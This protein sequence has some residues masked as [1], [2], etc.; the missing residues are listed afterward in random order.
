M[1]IAHNLLGMN[2]NRMY[3]ITNKRKASLTEKL[4]SGYKINRSAD[5]AAGL[6]I[7]EKMR[8][9]IRGLSQ[10]VENTQDGVSLCQVADGALAEVNDMLHRITEL[11]VK[12]ANGTNCEE[13]RQ[14]I[15][16]EVN[17]LL[18]EIDRI[19]DT[20]TF[21]ERPVFKGHDEVLTNADGSSMIEGDIPFQ[22]FALADVNLGRVPFSASSG[23]NNLQLQAI[24][25]NPASG[26]YGKT[27][28]LIYG[29]GS[30]S[31]SSFR[32]TDAAG[33]KTIVAL[34]SLQPA[35]YHYDSTNNIWSRDFNYVADGQNL[36]ITQKVQIEETNNDEKNY[37]ISYDF[38]NQQS[39]DVKIEFMFHADTAYNND[40]YCEGYY[41]DGNK[42]E[43]YCIYS[44][45]DSPLTDGIDSSYIDT[46][47]VPNSFSI[48]DVDKALAFSEKISFDSGNMPDS[49][50]IGYYN[51][52]DD[53]PYYDNLDSELGVNANRTDLG[54]TLYYNLE[55]DASGAGKSISFKYGIAATDADQNLNQVPIKRDDSATLEHFDKLPVWIQSGCEPDDGL[56]VTIEEMNNAVLGIRDLDVTNTQRAGETLERVKR[57]LHNVMRNRNNIGAQQ[58]RLEHIITNE[59]NIV[60]NTTAAESQIRDAD[61]AEEMIKLAKDNILEQVNQSL[62]AQTNQS[63]QGVMRLLS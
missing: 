30:T 56:D 40:D 57:A 5:D 37:V 41:I 38:T 59:N 4:S 44:K 25:D 53:W 61:M 28:N 46:T 10:G 8:R 11:A 27:Y 2:A 22:D 18:T 60:E 6:A 23:A 12:A 45:T 1:I 62:L 35:N 7:S 36:T 15:Q 16:E 49:V 48:V 43:K 50:S 39:S 63:P 54:F 31:N 47:G 34:D 33:Q 13:D 24:V 55:L 58:N 29:N 3:A 9:Q 21:N 32:I 19:G 26:A 51:R 42:V 14:Y 20:T 52:I 17:Q